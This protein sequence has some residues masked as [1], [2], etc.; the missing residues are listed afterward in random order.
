VFANEIQGTRV[1]VN[2]VCPGWVR[3]DTGGANA[4]RSVEQGVAT[5]IWLATLP[6][7]GPSGGLFGTDSRFPGDAEAA[8]CL[9]KPR[10]P[11]A[12]RS[13]MISWQRRGRAVDPDRRA[14]ERSR[15][16]SHG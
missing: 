8:R 7:D 12:V 11:I 4:T 13:G 9:G 3:T 14:E 15:E 2:A 10:W 5:T 16:A 1:K 6:D